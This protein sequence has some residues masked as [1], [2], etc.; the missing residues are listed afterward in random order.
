MKTLTDEQKQILKRADRWIENLKPVM[1]SVKERFDHARAGGVLDQTYEKWRK[2]LLLLGDLQFRI[3]TINS[4]SVELDLKELAKSMD[5]ADDIV[6][7]LAA[8][9]E[10]EGR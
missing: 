1:E 8:L 6:V 2:D 5:A 4:Y 7:E 10:K 3:C 9:A